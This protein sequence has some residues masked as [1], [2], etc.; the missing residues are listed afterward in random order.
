MKKKLVAALLTAAMAVSTLA[1]CGGSA[2]AQG[3]S[4]SAAASSGELKDLDTSKE[5]E[6]TM[7]VVSDRPAG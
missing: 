5:V 2:E 3:T 6:L 1:G 7:Y 4:G